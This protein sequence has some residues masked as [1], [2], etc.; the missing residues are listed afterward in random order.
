MKSLKVYRSSA[1]SGK[2][3]TLAK[4]YIKL[5]LVAPTEISNQTYNPRYF[6][7]IL[8]VTFTNDAAGEM[9]ARIVQQLSD[10]LSDSPRPT[11]KLLWE[12]LLQE[13]QQEYPYLRLKEKEWRKRASLLLSA[14]LHYYSDFSVSTID[15]FNNRIV[16]AFKREL[17]LPYHYELA[18]Q[19]E[20]WLELAVANLQSRIGMPEYASLSEV[21]TEFA[22]SRIVEDEKDWNLDKSLYDFANE[23]FRNEKSQLFLNSFANISM[24]QFQQSKKETIAYIREIA[25]QILA[26]AQ[27]AIALLQQKSLTESDFAY[28]EIPKY[29]QKIQRELV[30][31]ERRGINYEICY[32]GKRLTAQMKEGQEWYKEN[33]TKKTTINQLKPALTKFFDN[34]QSILNQNIAQL[35]IANHFLKNYYQLSTLS[36]LS[37]ELERIKRENHLVLL[38]ECNQKINQVVENEPVPFL[39]EHIGE[40]Y[41]HILIDEFQDT[42]TLQWHNL[43]PLVSNSLSQ[44]CLSLIVGDAKQSIYQWRGAQAQMLVDLPALSD[45]RSSSPLADSAYLFKEAYREVILNKN[46][47]SRDNIVLFNNQFFSQLRSSNKALNA[48]IQTFYSDVQQELNGKTGGHV[49]LFTYKDAQQQEEVF[50]ITLYYV[51]QC[52]ADGYRYG[53]ITILTRKNKEASFL[54]QRFIASGIEVVTTEALQICHAPIVKMMINF[55]KMLED[56][57]NILARFE[58]IA[59]WQC[60]ALKDKPELSNVLQMIL[61]EFRQIQRQETYLSSADFCKIISQRTGYNINLQEFAFQGVYHLAEGIVRTFELHAYTKEQP[62]LEKFM[63]TVEAFIGQKGNSIRAFLQM[64]EQKKDTISIKTFENPNAIKIQTIHKSKGLEYPVVMIPFACWNL[65]DRTDYVFVETASTCQFLKGF[66]IMLLRSTKELEYNPKYAELYQKNLHDIHIESLNLLY[67]ACT[68]AIDRLY[69]GF[70]IS[71]AKKARVSDYLSDFIKENQ[72]AP[73]EVVINA[74]Q[75]TELRITT[76][77]IYQDSRCY[78]HS[79]AAMIPQKLEVEKYFY[80]NSYPHIRL[81]ISTLNKEETLLSLQELHQARQYG[82]IAHYAFEKVK[83]EEDVEKAARA[84]LYEGLLR[85]EEKQIFVE[86]MKKIISLPKLREWF[87][88]KPNRIVR[89]EQEILLYHQQ[90]NMT[91]LRP[92]RLVFDGSNVAIIDYKTG[93]PQ[94]SHQFQLQQYA[95]ALKSAGYSPLACLLVY[96]ELFEVVEVNIVV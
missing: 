39:Y 90:N 11:S 68:R 8:A 7:H 24:N 42:S 15:S 51:Q 10:I 92:D 67:V 81:K 60:L 30:L 77:V 43:I 63:D 38:S 32:A 65:V 61:E 20:E 85:E 18:L 23:L 9:K 79:S 91:I 31:H 66:P 87:I 4:E 80:T 48:K 22:I 1:G 36:E 21:L 16:Q 94:S 33:S 5:A 78:S 69:V 73:Q 64:W 56:E 76:Y 3:F 75:E 86:L 50:K 44:D 93:E 89:N 82:K 19:H 45:I 96:T 88:K 2:T 71:E 12:I 27:Q 58:F 53:D 14:L 37:A 59:A 83:F 26:N 17:Q 46:F 40:R 54:A 74:Q 84:L 55:F 95:H 29:F 35:I 34:I 57:L 41:F 49:S 47:R 72:F 70:P 28:G 62:Y 6:R 25:Q 52:I 13:I